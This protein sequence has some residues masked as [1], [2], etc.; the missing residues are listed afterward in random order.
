M[1]KIKVRAPGSIMLM[2][3]H[4]VLFGHKALACAVDKYIDVELCPRSDDQVVVDSSLAQYQSTLGSLTPCSELSFV[5]AA[6]KRFKVQLSSGFELTIRSEFSHTVGLGSSA[7]VTAAVVA[8]LM[9]FVAE[10]VEP[11]GLFD[12]ALAVV[13]EV[14]G[15]RGSGSDLVASIYG[16]VV[17]YQVSPRTVERMS[18][19]PQLALYYAGYKTKTPDVLAIVEEKAQQNPAFYDAI[20][21]LMGSLTLQAEDAVA[22]QD[23]SRFGL[24]MNQYQGLM[25]TLGVSDLNLSE[26]I[27]RLRE[28]ADILA[29]KISGS[30]LGDCVLA[31]GTAADLKI[32]YEHIAITV[33]DQG[34][35]LEHH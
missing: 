6:I 23:W 32:G 9:A 17:A 16:G 22:A 13:H 35:T 30:G 20:Y 21:A 15:G 11:A 26:M 2:G 10:E 3:E 27:Y 7:A 4:A 33:S 25:D 8:A 5:L 18:A 12:H 29:S 1:S 14:Q 31:L 34:V 19:A 24:L 28:H